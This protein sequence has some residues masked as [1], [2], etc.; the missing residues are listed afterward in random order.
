M[1]C[2]NESNVQNINVETVWNDSEDKE[3]LMHTVHVYPAKFPAFIATKAFAYA[4]TE[5]VNRCLHTI[6]ASAGDDS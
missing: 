4:E 2:V 5:G 1:F 3:L 6:S